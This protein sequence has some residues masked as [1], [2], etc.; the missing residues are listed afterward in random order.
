MLPIKKK[1]E[2]AITTEPNSTNRKLENTV[3]TKRDKSSKGII[4]I[5]L[6]FELNWGVHDVFT[7]EQYEE[8]LLGARIAIPKILD[9][10]NQFGIHA[11]WATVGMLCFKNKKE[12]MEN[13]P[14]LHPSYTNTN[15]SPYEKL[16]SIGE[17][18]EQDPLHFGLS[19]IQKIAECPKQEVA[20]H[21]FSHFY[22]LE[23]GQT[24]EEFEA[25][26]KASLYCGIINGLPIKSLVFPRNQT[27]P[28]YLQVCKAYGI[29][30][31]RGN[32]SSWMYKASKFNGDG[33]WK[34]LIRL[35]DCYLN[36]SGHNTYP[37]SEVVTEPI[38]NLPSSRFLRPYSKKLKSLELL[39]LRR[40]KKSIINAAKN[41]EVFHLWWHPHNFGKNIEENLQF[42]TEILHLVEKLRN[43]YGF[44]SL[45]MAEASSLALQVKDR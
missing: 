20:S 4:I 25:D 1:E 42:L 8:N 7:L 18:E 3:C 41:G 23:E 5:S 27:N 13:L 28:R 35:S 36:I 39:R 10:F 45:T 14:P 37:L 32:E 29:E 34:R 30:S 44:E 22:C 11:T 2:E 33:S 17:N 15:F 43:E 6:D 24:I 40:I 12:L 16:D 9:L 26:L 19:L 21:T 31:F 38:V